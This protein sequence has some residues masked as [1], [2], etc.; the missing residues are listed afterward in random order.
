MTKRICVS[1]SKIQTNHHSIM[2]LHL[3]LLVTGVALLT[4]CESIVDIPPQPTTEP[5]TD[6]HTIPVASA[7]NS[8]RGFLASGLTGRADNMPV[9]ANVFAVK[10][11][12]PLSRSEDT[13]TGDLLY[14]VNFNNNG[15]YAIIAADDR[16]WDDILVVTESGSL[17]PTDFQSNYTRTK[18]NRTYSSYPIDGPG[19]F[20]L[21][22]TGD[23]LYINPNTV[24]FYVDSIG[25]YLVGNLDNNSFWGAADEAQQ[26]QSEAQEYSGTDMADGLLTPGLCVQYAMYSVNNGA[27]RFQ[28]SVDIDRLD[29]GATGGYGGYPKTDSIFAGQWETVVQTTNLLDDFKRWNQGS[30][31]ND[32][33]P[34]RHLFGFFGGHHKADA[35]CIPLAIAK[36][37][38]YYES[39]SPE[40][41]SRG[42]INWAE[43]KW[44]FYTPEGKLSAARL[45]RSISSGCDSWYFYQGTFT[46][47]AKATAFMR[48]AGFNNAHSLEYTHERVIEMLEAGRPVIIYS[49][50]GTWVNLAHSHCW[51][52][53]GYKTYKRQLTK[54]TYSGNTLINT[55]TTEETREMV[56]CN[57][58]WGLLQAGY[59]V[60][61]I[62]KFNSQYVEKEKPEWG[63]DDH[64]HYNHLLKIIR[65]EID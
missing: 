52:I 19:F 11:P 28:T 44:S 45:I 23:E 54:K 51:T 5:T 39:D 43:L 59:Y 16:I 38:A 20:T 62:F 2:K 40:F 26:D 32:M 36:V 27:D 13:P 30:P 31:F 34:E 48:R 64:T 15:G 8:L 33:H 42:Q 7:L 41:H 60:S 56:H 17:T 3:S 35:G 21:P 29:S 25:E 47:P 61:G 58:G 65:Y 10:A 55:Q 12:T 46:L 37:A 1:L 50:P 18:G 57:F 24:S 4:S 63:N 6:S 9:I 49:I 53:D 22:E 14:V